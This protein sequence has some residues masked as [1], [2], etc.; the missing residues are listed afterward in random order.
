MKVSSS[1]L[2][3]RL[4]LLPSACTF[5]GVCLCASSSSRLNTA[6]P[7]APS[8][9]GEMG[10]GGGGRSSREPRFGL[11]ARRAVF[12]QSDISISFPLRGESSSLSLCFSAVV[13][14]LCV[15]LIMVVVD[16]VRLVPLETRRFGFIQRDWT[17]SSC[18]CVCCSSLYDWPPGFIH[19]L[20]ISPS[21]ICTQRP[22]P[23]PNVNHVH[24]LKKYII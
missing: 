24:D 16:S 10:W 6:A 2:S 5:R 14:I 17:A 4:S 21:C 23:G 3:C 7:C 19:P 22:G 18:W 15:Q 20:F 13:S 9:K 8:I 1:L 11:D 12:A